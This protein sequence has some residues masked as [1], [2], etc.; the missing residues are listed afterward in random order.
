MGAADRSAL[1]RDDGPSDAGHADVSAARAAVDRHLGGGG[2]V[3]AAPGTAALRRPRILY[4]TK[5][6]PFPPATAGD[7][8]Y[9]R[10]IITALAPFADLCVLCAA[11]DGGAADP[12]AVGARW[13]IRGKRRKGRAGSVLSIL[14][15]IAWATATREIRSALAGMLRQPWDAII[16]D[17]IGTGYALRAA[18]D[19]RKAHPA[20]RIA[21][22]SHEHE[23]AV[24][25]AKYSQYRLS[26]PTRIA[27]SLDARK[28]ANLELRMLRDVDLVTLINPADR[29][30]FAP[31]APNQHYFN[32]EPGYDGMYVGQRTIDADTPRRVLLLGGRRSAQKRMIL[33]NWLAEAY[34]P[35]TA[36]GIGIVVAG[37]MEDSLAVEIADRF[38]AVEAK[39]F[40]ED[41]ATL[42]A[43]SRAGIIPDT[44]GGGFKMRLLTHIFM[45]LPIIGL[46][47]AISGLPTENGSG[48]LAA[49]TLPELTA[50]IIDTIDDPAKL[51]ALQE[52]A[53]SD[54]RAHFDWEKRIEALLGELLR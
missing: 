48:Y 35:L 46:G 16:L 45:R 18:L 25:S 51:D 15:S 8:V 17:N 28:V 44:V 39:G 31:L 2:M 37:D 53:F 7:A 23:S 9:S 27:A 11:N 12:S 43:S 5:V 47:D 34:A 24:R 52:T 4:L 36:A 40:V 21:Y 30:A 41:P 20:V 29:A 32:L 54:C 13:T 38:P 22:I 6:Y 42:I 19:Y 1:S 49:A 3:M 10:G 50:L 33:A 14:P 26:V